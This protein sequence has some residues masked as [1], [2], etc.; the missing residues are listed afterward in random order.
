MKPCTRGLLG[1]LLLLP[2]LA[3]AHS[4]HDAS[5]FAHGFAHPIGGLDH[6]LAMI[7]VGILASR[8][9][10][11][12]RFAVPAGFVTSMIVGAVLSENAVPLVEAMIALSLVAFG[13]AIAVT[14]VV[15]F[16]IVIGAVAVFGF[17]HGHAHGSE[18]SGTLIPFSAGFVLATTLLHGLGL[19]VTLRLQHIAKGAERA[20][21]LLGGLVAGAGLV[22]IGL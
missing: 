12:A 14:R 17:F 16:A 10:G 15:P 3:L 19:W 4:G 7:A 21:R 8:F 2:G 11:A 6:L 9:Q 22:L 5:T 13:L 18:A 1:V 20:V